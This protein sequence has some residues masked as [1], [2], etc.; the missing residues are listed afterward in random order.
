MVAAG[1]VSF[2]RSWFQSG[3]PSTRY[4]HTLGLL[5][6]AIALPPSPALCTCTDYD[7]Y[8]HRVGELSLGWAE[9]AMVAISGGHAYIAAGFSLKIAEL[10]PD[11]SNPVVVGD[12]P[13]DGAHR[14]AVRLFDLAGR[15]RACTAWTGLSAGPHLRMLEP[16]DASGRRLSAGCYF[17]RVDGPAGHTTARWVLLR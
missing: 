11:P 13:I 14:V 6:V 4:W 3:T 16:Q 10:L 1:T 2:T 5:A 12:C 15:E 9:P 7:P 8:L 17:V